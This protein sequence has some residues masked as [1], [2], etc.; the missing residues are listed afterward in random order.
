MRSKLCASGRQ[1]RHESVGPMR[2]TF[3][4]PMTLAQKLACV[5]MTPLGS[6]V[7]PEV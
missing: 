4:A 7:V 5:S 3:S 2:T 6:P 1:E